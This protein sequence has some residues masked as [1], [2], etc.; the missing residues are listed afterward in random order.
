[1]RAVEEAIHARLT[2]ALPERRFE[3]L[4]AGIVGEHRKLLKAVERGDGRAAAAL[5]RTHLQFYG[6]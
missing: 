4:R 3:K 1:M 6:T 2:E 5:L